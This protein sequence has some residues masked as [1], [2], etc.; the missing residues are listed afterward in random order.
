MGIGRALAFLVILFAG[1]I[2]CEII[3]PNNAFARISVHV[4]SYSRTDYGAGNQNWSIDIDGKG[5]VFIGN[6]SGLLTLRGSS[7]RLSPLEMLTPVRS[8][9]YHDGKVYTGSFE[10]FGYWSQ[11]DEGHL[12]YN[13]LIPKLQGVNIRN[14]EFWRIE[15]HGGTIYFQSF[16]KLFML[17]DGRIDEI[18]L[19][20]PM[21]FLMKSANRLFIQEID[22]GLY[23]IVGNQLQFLEGSQIF[24][25]TEIKAVIHLAENRFLIGTSSKGVFQYDGVTWSPWN[26]QAQEQL[27]DGKINNGLRLGDKLV[28]GTI[29]KGL[30]ILD[31][32]GRL[33]TNLHSGNFLQNNT[34]LALAGDHDNNLWIGLDKGIDF[35][36][37]NS[38]VESY[39]GDFAHIGAVYDAVLQNEL[40]YVGTNQGIHIFE[41]DE[42]GRFTG[43]ELMPGS[44][45]QVW[46]L[47]EI[48]G[49]LFCGHNDGTYQ[50]IG[51][52][53]VQLSAY[54]GGFNL[55]RVVGTPQS[56]LVQS[57]YYHL[58]VYHFQNG[59][60]NDSHILEG[61]EGPARFLEI[62]FMGNIWLGH[63]LTGIY[64]LQPAD[65][66][67]T[68][69]H[70]IEMGSEHGLNSPTNRVFTMDN[71]IVVLTGQS[72]L[73]WD[74]LRQ[75]FIPFDEVIPSLQGFEK[76][77]MLASAGND[78]YWFFKKG[79]IGLFQVRFGK[80][81]LLYRILPQMY[82]I[83]MVE[84]YE[85][86]VKLN[87][88]LHLVCQV[89]GFSILN[90]ARLNRLPL[91][92]TPPIIEG[93]S[94][95]RKP[96]STH[97]ISETW[98]GLKL[99]GRGLNNVRIR[100]FAHEPGGKKGFFQYR[101]TGIDQHWSGWIQTNEVTYY[102]LPPG[103]YT[104][105]VRTLDSKGIITGATDLTFRIRAP[106][107]FSGMAFLLYAVLLI[108]IFWQVRLKYL[109][110]HF[111]KKEEILRQQKEELIRQKE[112]AEKE[113]ITLAN[114]KLQSEV[115]LKNA[116]LANNTMSLIR[117]NELLGEILAEVQRQ[118]ED[119]GRAVPK[120][121]HS[122]I[123]DLIEDTKR[124]DHDMEQFE[125]LFYQAHENFFHILK[126]NYPDLTKS[127]LRLCAYLRLNL[128][129]KEIAPLLNI[130]IRGVEER[131]YRLRK[132]IGLKS[133][134]G[135]SEFILAL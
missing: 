71:R 45:G 131:R 5:N 33:L 16:G 88:S 75:V 100:F 128:S 118:K 17:S 28:F 91:K 7:F 56:Y 31:L 122:R 104:F 74:A 120:K 52:Q 39:S 93:I 101:L 127:D 18:I 129:S 1:F 34:V 130:S 105:S 24:G 8:V 68:L 47:E 44:Q 26:N 25:Q 94:F 50:I 9:R 110:N 114:E 90:L 22:G 55:R 99:L 46:F 79:E 126:S 62:D 85:N 14:E 121:F 57:T 43:G 41:K 109:R 70:A 87:D 97:S 64:K 117:K 116:Q 3:S 38:P 2:F 115:G 11:N 112:R 72:I 133:D 49:L 108:A 10:E 60:W 119:L 102:R 19:P 113:L 53:M 80:A 89:N 95:W 58:V 67:Q 92:D 48:D 4:T 12:S 125:K 107:F 135:L 21:L 36:D 98:E 103:T 111:R 23:E 59:Q 15:Q 81:R 82:G 77:T 83:D 134:Q 40:L 13:S 86:I 37:L 84:G 61:W 65:G 32:D 69:N 78:R 132:R 63:T 30:F 123:I 73:Q 106:W 54:K 35:I 42:N 96:E 66:L 76:A 124:N 20:G 27:A 6:T 29:L 51:R